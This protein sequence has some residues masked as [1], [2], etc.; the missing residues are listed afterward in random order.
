MFR[1]L[2]KNVEHKN[3]ARETDGIDCPKSVAVRVL[4]D[5]QHTR[6]PKSLERARLIVFSASLRQVKSIS[7]QINDPFRQ[8]HQV[9]LAA[10]H[11]E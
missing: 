7:E 6:R 11:P 8:R 2:L 10:A 4:D 5:L 3:S 1:L 9:F